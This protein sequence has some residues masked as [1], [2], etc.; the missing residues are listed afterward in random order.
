[1]TGSDIDRQELLDD[2]ALVEY[3]L[4]N[5]SPTERQRI[6]SMDVRSRSVRCLDRCGSCYRESLLVV[7]GVP[8]TGETC[9][10]LIASRDSGETP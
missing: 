5:V 6:E 2:A 1:M 8:V 10:Q 9:S 7:D 3:C 4:A